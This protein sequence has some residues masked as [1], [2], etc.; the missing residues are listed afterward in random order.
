MRRASSVFLALALSSA[1]VASGQTSGPAK[2][3]RPPNI[4][5]ILADD[6]G[7]ADASVTG[8]R[9]YR[10]PRIDRM[11]AEGTRFT[12]YYVAEPI[13]SASR[14]SMLTGRYPK[15]TGVDGALNPGAMGLPQEELT[16]AELLK[17]SGYATGMFGKWHLG[18]QPGSLPTH[19]GFDEY[20]GLP[21]SNDMWPRN[22]NAAKPWPPL[23]WI[24]GDTP[25]KEIDEAAQAL[26]TR[27]VTDRS[28]DFIKR[29]AGAP[30]FLYVAHPMPHVPIYASDRFK[31]KTAAGLYADVMTELDWS[32]GQILDTLSKVG[33]DKNTIVA[34]ASDNG[35]WIMYGNHAGS[36]F[37]FRQGKH[38]TFEGGV[39]VPLIVR[40]PGKVLAAKTVADP[41]M[42]VDLL[43]TLVRLAGGEVP[44]DRIVDG[45]DLW[46]LLTGKA[47]DAPLHDALFF[48]G[49]FSGLELHAVRAGRWKLHVPHQYV[50]AIPANDGARG[51]Y[52]PHDLLLSLFDLQTDP[53]ESTNVADANPDVVEALMK[54]I[55]SARQDLGDALTKREGKNV[56]LPPA[57]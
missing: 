44:K 36:A 11:A 23:V 6:M 14:A 5:I 16:I 54:H 4:V 9:G 27:T 33:L 35:P 2:A 32:V 56:G 19:H 17:T 57:K 46:P 20:A 28:V 30:F 1:G 12:D 45:K 42:N 47:T 52:E 38:T 10:T 53:G 41:A 55:E 51:K 18:D 13:C 15:R 26:L 34:F 48:F 24:E 22:P 31:G 25:A 29:H 8:A 39:R 50:T 3:S 7:Y 43:P 49:G 37:P 40:W 21:Y